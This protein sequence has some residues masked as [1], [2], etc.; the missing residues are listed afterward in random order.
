[1]VNVHIMIIQICAK[2]L[3]ITVVQAYVPKTISKRRETEGAKMF[4][5]AEKLE[6]KFYCSRNR[7]KNDTYKF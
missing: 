3:K 2:P 1:M 4:N 5:W 6:L 7:K